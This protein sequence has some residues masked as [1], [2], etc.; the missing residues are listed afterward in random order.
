MADECAISVSIRLLEHRRQIG[1]SIW[2]YLWL[3]ARVTG[4]TLGIV[5]NGKP[6]STNRIA[7]ELG[8]SREST[9]ANL[10]RLEAGRF[11]ERS[12]APGHAYIYRVIFVD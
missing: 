10:A 12:A 9:L 6:I 2:E 3:M 5:E 1:S 7:S 11:I 4:E 8:R